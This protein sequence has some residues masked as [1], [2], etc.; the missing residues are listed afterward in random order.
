M[1]AEGC[2][3]K[4]ERENREEKGE[5]N[6]DAETKS[7]VASGMARVKKKDHAPTLSSFLAVA[8][9]HGNHLGNSILKISR[10]LRFFFDPLPPFD[11]LFCLSTPLCGD[12]H[13]P[14]GPRG[15]DKKFIFLRARRAEP[16][17]F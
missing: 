5:K 6:L 11:P 14:Y 2:S 16:R 8:P 17:Y 7:G 13:R 4:V 3:G 10:L 15:R 9:N 12:E 1:T